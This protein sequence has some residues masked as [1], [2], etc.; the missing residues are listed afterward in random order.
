MKCD[1]CETNAHTKAD[2]HMKHM[3]RYCTNHQGYA[4][5]EGGAWKRMSNQRKR[6]ICATCVGRV[7]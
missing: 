4:K 6:W 1:Y 5:V 2:C 3:D 7:K